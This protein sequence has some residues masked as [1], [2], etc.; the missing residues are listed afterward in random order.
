MTRGSFM[1][2]TLPPLKAVGSLVTVLCIGLQLQYHMTQATAP[3]GTHWKAGAGVWHPH[4]EAMPTLLRPGARQL[5]AGQAEIMTVEP[6]VL[7]VRDYITVNWP[8]KKMESL[9]PTSPH[10]E[11]SPHG[12]II[13][14]YCPETAADGDYVDYLS[15]PKEETSV[16]FGPV[17]NMRCRY[18]FRYLR[19]L[20]NKS[21]EAYAQSPPVGFAA[22]SSQPTQGRLSE[23]GV[24][25]EMNVMWVSD[26]NNMSVVQYVLNSSRHGDVMKANNYVMNATGKAHTYAASDLCNAPAN[27]VAALKFR[28]PGF[29]HRVRLMGLSSA[30]RYSYRYGSDG[31]WSDWFSFTTQPAPG[32][33]EPVNFFVFGDL[34]E[35]RDAAGPPPGD[36]AYT[37]MSRIEEDLKSMPAAGR[38]FNLLLHV[39]D[40]SY[41][42][43]AAYQWEQFG[44]LVQRV[45]TQIPYYVGIGNHEYDHEAGGEND[46]SHADGNG[47]HPSWGNYGTDSAGEC[48]VPVVNRFSMPSTAAQSLQPFWYSHDYGLI[49]VVWL[50][51]EHDFYPSSD[52]YKFLVADLATVN[53][54]RTPWVFVMGHRPMYC[55]RVA[56]ANYI[57]QVH[58]REAYEDALYRFGV[59]VFWSGHYHSYERT[60]AVYKEKCAKTASGGPA[61]TVHIMVGMA[62]AS[63]DQPDWQPSTWAESHY[64]DY[65]YNRVTVANATHLLSEYVENE[66]G[67]VKDS[68][69]IV[70]DH[71][72]HAEAA[73]QWA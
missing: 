57:I 50:S 1:G 51:T 36:R 41:A 58:Q 48:A 44:D 19:A 73:K 46:P 4:E 70:S 5:R 20:L 49:H 56:S 26:L 39:G 52:M 38:N 10:I 2:G 9:L 64:V 65:G 59:D 13:A 12:D 72:W 62:G 61:A 43:G 25:G 63:H 6:S 47:Y 18:Q 7:E 67:K 23:T 14:A 60:C 69:W 45:A 33:A 55:S 34:G 32:S 68:V 28:D 3:H 24:V 22:G 11:G 66:S 71:R 35:W 17:V 21:Y 16:K 27:E 37:T 53:R 31:H 54:T 15:V 40:I 42:R 29:I 8:K 30:T